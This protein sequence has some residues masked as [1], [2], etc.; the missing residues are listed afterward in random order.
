[1]SLDLS[2]ISSLNT[3][4]LTGYGGWISLAPRD[5]SVLMLGYS[6][7]HYRKCGLIGVGVALLKEV[8]HYV[9]GL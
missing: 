1:M 5:S 7:W 2:H 9:G 8:G 3:N 6:E 4:T